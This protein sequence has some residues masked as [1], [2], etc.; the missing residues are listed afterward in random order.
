MIHRMCSWRVEEEKR[1]TMLG[2]GIQ[3]VNTG[4]Y[5]VAS[6]KKFPEYLSDSRSDKMPVKVGLSSIRGYFVN[7]RMRE[8]LNLWK[9][10]LVNKSIF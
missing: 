7:E 4:K 3:C 10:I 6:S 2:K 9:I 1:M 5:A 8:K